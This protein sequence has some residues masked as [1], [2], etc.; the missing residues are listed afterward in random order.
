[1]NT[2]SVTVFSGEVFA[3]PQ[4]IQRID[5]RS[6]HGWQVRYHGTKMFSDGAAGPATA[7]AAATR[8]LVRRIAEHPAPVR[9]QHG[10]SANKTSTLPAGISGPIVQPATAKRA[11][12]ASLSVLIPRFGQPSRMRK[13]YIASQSTYSRS[14]FQ[15][16]L[17]RAI[18]LR[19]EAE[20]SYRLAATRAKRKEAVA[21]KAMARSLVAAR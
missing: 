8:E 9:L 14:K 13:V 19:T 15:A 5:T 21:L 7:L 3:V 4:C 10:P 20:Q 12:S 17:A 16:A 18:E 6:T 1:M 11:S 2:R